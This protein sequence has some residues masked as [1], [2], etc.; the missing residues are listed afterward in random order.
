[1]RI[2]LLVASLWLVTSPLQGKIVFYSKRDGN[3]EIYTMDSDGSNQT[4]LT[5]NEMSDASPV[6]SPNGRQIAFHRERNG[7]LEIYV[8]EVDGSNQRNLTR[9]PASDGFPYW[10]PDGNQIAFRSTRNA[11]KD[12]RL[13]V[14]VMD[15]DGS[16]VRQVTRLEFAT[17]PQ[18][19]PDGTQILFEGSID[20]GRQI[21]AIRPDGRGRWQISEPKPN[22]GMLLGDWSP[23]GKK[24][25]Y[26]EFV[27]DPGKSVPVI[28]TLHPSGRQEV[29]KREPVPLPQVGWEVLT[30]E[31]WA[32][33]GE[34]ILFAGNRD[35][36]NY[37]IY[38][39]HL[40]DEHL[41]QLT[42]HR[43][44]D[45]APHEWDPRLPVSPQGL[46]PKRWGEIKSNSHRHRVMG[47]IEIGPTP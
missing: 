28:A 21:F 34:S 3:T 7:N 26:V 41:T 31:T 18:W 20:Q 6:W 43:K 8:M 27:A 39:F 12:H 38:R 36:K 11:D 40:R 4:R 14:F 24:I 17:N 32:A 30:S 33:D 22:T 35:G 1:M 5:F 13:N 37:D 15:A 47:A 25:L 23:D 45:V 44:D 29:V 2:V 10:S 46:A 19:S 16:R 42:D 9:H